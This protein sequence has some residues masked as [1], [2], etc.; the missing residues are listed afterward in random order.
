[1]ILLT[2]REIPS[3][4]TDHACPKDRNNTPHTRK[5][6]PFQRNGSAEYLIRRPLAPDR[7]RPSRCE[8]SIPQT[9]ATP[10]PSRAS[11]LGSG[12]RRG[13]YEGWGEQRQRQKLGQR[14]QQTPAGMTPSLPSLS[15]RNSA[16][17]TQPETPLWPGS[18][19]Y[20][21]LRAHETKANLVCRLLLA[22]D[23]GES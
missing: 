19:S 7:G 11:C 16:P 15:L 5:R 10:L 9:S 14:A 12:S 20:T 18:V 23:K 8:G 4:Q 17:G 1:M 21:H 22:R 13:S 3:S 2:L 6:S